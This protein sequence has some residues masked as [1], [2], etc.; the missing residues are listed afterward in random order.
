MATTLS[1]TSSNSSAYEAAAR[2]DRPPVVVRGAED[3]AKRTEPTRQKRRSLFYRLLQIPILFVRAV[4]PLSYLFI[5]T[6]LWHLRMHSATDI[7]A[8]LKDRSV[9]A[10]SFAGFTS[11]IAVECL[12][13]PYYLMARK[14]LQARRPVH[15]AM[16]DPESRKRLVTRC[17]ESLAVAAANIDAKHEA[18]A[19]TLSSASANITE[20]PDAAA[21]VY[22][23]Q[24]ISGWFLGAPFSSVLRDNMRSWVA[25]AFMDQDLALLD[26]KESAEVDGLLAVLENR[27]GYVFPPGHDPEVKCIRLTLDPVVAAHR[28]ALYYAFTR[29]VDFGSKTALRAMGFVRR[30][31]DPLDCS[32]AG[33]A[34]YFYRPAQLPTPRGALPI[35]FVHGIGVGFAVYLP[36][37][38]SLP[39]N[40]PIYLLEWPHVAMQVRD[41]VPSVADTRSLLVGML[42]K[43]KH[44]KATFI[45]HSLGSVAV[46]WLLNSPAHRSRVGSVVLLDPVTFLLCDPT[47]A[48]NFLY[49]PP[50]EPLQLLMNYFVSRE[51]YIAHSLSRHFHWSHNILFAEDLPTVAHQGLK[52]YVVLSETDLIVPSPRVR[53][54][55]EVRNYENSDPRNTANIVYHEGRNH[56]EMLFRPKLLSHTVDL[57]K[58]ACGSVQDGPYVSPPPSPPR[59]A[60]NSPN[61]I[62][63]RTSFARKPEIVAAV[64]TAVA[65]AAV[66]AVPLSDKAPSWTTMHVVPPSVVAQVA[67]VRSRTLINAQRPKLGAARRTQA[68]SA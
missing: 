3:P 44:P 68:V 1:R 35:V 33:T 61:A 37:L 41:D 57:I 48:Y 34:A 38:A 32:G 54:Y 46:A 8:L 17:W 27:M 28:P 47:T 39:R 45:G 59:S 19:Q 9:P 21:S 64:A 30:E 7:L 18:T 43:D 60:R 58:R 50:T 52:N 62:R 14:R 55:L 22:I 10:L 23:R 29:A 24:V 12:W 26:E 11:W 66:A 36:L 20:A 5:F 42:A 63:K 15:H 31:L 53:Q 4:T 67:D 2:A 16:N 13:Y 40:V 25:W 49:R 51:L 6:L 56:G 65:A